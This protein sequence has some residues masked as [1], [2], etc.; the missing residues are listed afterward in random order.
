MKQEPQTTKAGGQ[1]VD[2]GGEKSRDEGITRQEPLVHEN[3]IENIQDENVRDDNSSPQGEQVP[4]VK[5]SSSKVKKFIIFVLFAVIFGG[6][7]F[8]YNSSNSLFFISEKNSA[9]KNLDDVGSSNYKKGLS[10][11]F[12]EDLNTSIDPQEGIILPHPLKSQRP[13]IDGAVQSALQGEETDANDTTPLTK[14][15]YFKHREALGAL[16]DKILNGRAYLD[17]LVQVKTLFPIVRIPTITKYAIFGVMSDTDLI[18]LGKN[19]VAKAASLPLPYEKGQ[20]DYLYYFDKFLRSMVI[21]IPKELDSTKLDGKIGLIL[22]NLEAGQFMAAQDVIQKL[23]PS[24]SIL[25]DEFIEKS[26]EKSEI[27]KEM[28]LLEEALDDKLFP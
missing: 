18:K 27:K 15:E 3:I 5:K 10:E 11:E 6:A 14:E 21:I 25:F 28:T 16:F 13:M 1:A 20:E 22:R 23:P 4:P 19:S 2:E 7:L 24:H 12:V 26:Y 8:F 9:S 17:D